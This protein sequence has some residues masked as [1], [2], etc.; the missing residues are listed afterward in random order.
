MQGRQWERTRDFSAGSRCMSQGVPGSALLL[1]GPEGCQAGVAS[2]V[3]YRT[4]SLLSGSSLV[5]EAGREQRAKLHRT[6]SGAGKELPLN[7]TLRSHA[8]AGGAVA[9]STSASVLE[10]E[11]EDTPWQ[12]L[13]LRKDRG[14]GNLL[15][16]PTWDPQGAILVGGLLGGAWPLH[17]IQSPVTPDV[18]AT[19]SSLFHWLQP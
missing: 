7:R 19:K 17:H 6:P 9:S 12:R 1:W 10:A 8:V 16:A 11:Q 2:G 15:Q 3:M 4:A 14:A 13:V 5:S 18:W